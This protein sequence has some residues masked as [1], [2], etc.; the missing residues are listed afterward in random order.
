MR[1]LCG[2]TEEH[3]ENKQDRWTWGEVDGYTGAEEKEQVTWHRWGGSQ[4]L[5]QRP[6]SVGGRLYTSNTS[7]AK[8]IWV[9]SA[10][11]KFNWLF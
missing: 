8:G 3:S 5:R 6:L 2:R 9:V 1:V 4:A 7:N 11:I 10:G